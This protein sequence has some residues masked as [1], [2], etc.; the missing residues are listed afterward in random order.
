MTLAVSCEEDQGSVPPVS[1]A[2]DSATMSTASMSATGGTVGTTGT[3]TDTDGETDPTSTSSTSGDPSG[4][5][6]TG[7]PTNCGE[8]QCSDHGSCVLDDDGV[9]YCVCDS[10][11][12]LDDRTESCVV[13]T[14]CV[15]LRFL[16]DHCRQL[17]N[18]PPA[19]ALFFGVDF[20]AGTAVTPDKLQELGLLFQVLEDG[21]DISDNVESEATIIEKSVENYVMLSL[22]MSNSAAENEDLPALLTE[23]RGL[24]QALEPA[25]GDPDVYVSLQIFGRFVRELRPFT[26]DL[27]D[28]DGI[29]TEIAADP[30]RF[31]AL[32][33]GN[34][35][36]LFEATKEGIQNT[37]RIRELRDG[38][39]DDGVLTTGTV[40]V[41]TDGQDT[42]NG[43]LDQQLINSTTNQVISIGISA[44]I[45]DE[46]LSAI[47]RD[48]SFLVPTPEDW[49]EAFDEIAQRVDE[50]PD[51]SY[52]LAYCSSATEG[53]P[54]VEVTI[55][56]PG[57]LDV[58]SAL[59]QF[60]ADAFSSNPNAVC[61]AS[62][63]ETECDAQA[64]GGLTACGSCGDDQCCVD[65]QCA[66]PGS[67]S[68]GEPDCSGQDEI[69]YPTDQV[70]DE[71][72]TED[73]G[74]CEDPA[75]PGVPPPVGEDEPCDPACDPGVTYC[76]ENDQNQPIGCAP[77][78]GDPVAG[79]CDPPCIPGVEQCL[80]NA[81]GD[82]LGCVQATDPVVCEVP[83]QCIS[84]QCYFLNPENPLEGRFCLPEARIFDHCGTQDGGCE[85]GSYCD[86]STCRAR[87]RELEQCSGGQQ[88][89]SAECADFGPGNFCTNTF[90]C[91]WTWNEKI[92]E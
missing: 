69:C 78:L 22:D 17:I 73:F 56:G 25:P 70:C 26:R 41:I 86:G 58:T 45:D 52:L 75:P 38:I 80:T 49:V 68:P 84:N 8:I 29:L 55:Q 5:T 63:F 32:V 76:Q 15:Q 81:N 40:V 46:Q 23:L 21:D 50:Y 13:D 67:P 33:N 62:L 28:I 43:S 30:T 90:Q 51:R 31:S 24:V 10:G 61:D 12:V 14:S 72:G 36:V 92:G 71:D 42:S 9:P 91:H 48:G 4:S 3:A 74:V 64:C 1:T 66:G 35:T 37:Q 79:P 39:T 11:F 88:C 16:E 89:R 7:G 65:G 6:S 83:E 53:E 20:C 44:Q 18:G 82:A 2:T 27:D 57:L 54:S 34:G 47:G 87:K 77:V 19:V 60:S 59:C 85:T